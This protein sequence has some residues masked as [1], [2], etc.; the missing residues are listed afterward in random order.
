M[1]KLNFYAGSG[2]DRAAHYRKNPDWLAE[3]LSPA[4]G[5]TRL[6]PYWRGKHL[7]AGP[8]EAPVPVF[9]SPGA[10]WWRDLALLPP[11]FL[12][13]EGEISYFAVDFSSIE[14]VETHPAI[15]A[16]GRFQEMRAVARLMERSIGGL[17]AYIRALML[18]HEKHRF[19][20]SCG[21]PTDIAEAGHSRRCTNPTC[22]IS[23]FPRHDPA[24]I[25]LVHDGDRCV[26]GRQSR[27]PT[28]M[29]STLAGF[30][31]PGESL[32]ETVAREC[33]EEAGIRVTD[34]RYH[35]SQP[36]PFP[37]S[38]MLGFHARAATQDLR[39]DM[40]ELEDVRWFS[41]DYL[42]S[43]G[44]GSDDFRLPP[45]DSISR[46]LINCWLNGDCD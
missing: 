13:V 43:V 40:D 9:L 20:G 18:W 29:Y 27:F 7:V 11:V 38:L 23:H 42:S 17:Y 34:I 28:G 5:T 4:G 36:W 2:L 45:A 32:E 16:L 1:A 19:C 12:G 22:G 33:Y 37:S 15:T 14:T 6:V 39:P 30:V 8:D 44:P 3:R 25:M 26:L 31:E 10:D 21:S 46:Q 41:R 35:S 24:V